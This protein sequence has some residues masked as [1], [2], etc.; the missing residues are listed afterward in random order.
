MLRE[1]G[2][3][4]CFSYIWIFA[5]LTNINIS[6]VFFLTLDLPPRGQKSKATPLFADHVL[7]LKTQ[8]I[9]FIE[10]LLNYINK[11]STHIVYC[12][13]TQSTP[14]EFSHFFARKPIIQG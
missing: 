1:A 10:F 14:H 8:N 9:L 6:F 4:P 7:H 3:F 2:L 13:Y 5:A 12:V 11:I